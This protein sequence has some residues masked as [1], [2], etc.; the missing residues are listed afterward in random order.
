MDVVDAGLILDHT[1]AR[2]THQ[3]GLDRL[4]CHG[5]KNSAKM[6]I[7]WYDWL[8]ME[9]ECL[10][11]IQNIKW[12]DWLRMVREWMWLDNKLL[13]RNYPLGP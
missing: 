6:S 10:R 3:L 4:G 13:Y 8:R 7:K 1:P 5:R 11:E 9:R 12:Y 2:I